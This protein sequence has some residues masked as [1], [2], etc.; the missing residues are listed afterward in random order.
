MKFLLFIAL[1]TTVVFSAHAERAPVTPAPVW[2]LKDVEG[3]LVSSEQFKGKVVVVDFWATWCPPCRAEIPGY[4]KLQEKYGKDGLVVV[5]ISLDQQGPGIVK[6]FM[7]KN[8]MNY[9][10]VMGD[11]AVAQSF[12][13]IEAIPTTF[14]I[15]RAGNIRDKKIGGE[16]AAV[17]EKRLLG[18]LK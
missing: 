13:G 3:N 12:G 8:K 16:E 5:G 18:L 9:P 7:A 4:V 2:K 11:E 14:I 1:F 10:V 15:D 17:F 6:E